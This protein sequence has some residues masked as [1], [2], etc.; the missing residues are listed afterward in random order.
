[1]RDARLCGLWLAL[2]LVIVLP[3]ELL[4]Q[5]DQSRTQA[6]KPAGGQV[7]RALASSFRLLLLEHSG[8]VV[9]QAK[10][11]RELG[12]PFFQDYARSLRIPTRWADGDGW[13]VNYVGHP[14]HGAAAGRTWLAHH[15]ASDLVIGRS[16]YWSSR[17]RA[18]AWAALFS[19]QFELGPLS[20][21]SIG[22]V[23]INQH[24]TGWVD[25]VMTPI[26]ALGVLVAEDALDQHVMRR[27]ERSTDNRFVLGTMRTVLNPSRAL[28]NIVDGRPPWFRLRGPLR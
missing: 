26:G 18:A 8:R 15:P 22:N 20:E 5:E 1:M 6:S 3:Q 24:K 4:A 21:A 14:I 2:G 10:T 23:G 7:Q 12:G 11:R 16:K 13:F 17:L 19:V 25:H 27:I 9:F 28:A